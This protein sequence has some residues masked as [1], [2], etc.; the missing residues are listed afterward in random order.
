MAKY[1]YFP[2]WHQ[3]ASSCE[4]TINKDVW[5]SMSKR[6]QSLVEQA[7]SSCFI[8]GILNQD[9]HSG[10]AMRKNAEKYGVHNMIYPPEV[11]KAFQIT[12]LEIVAEKSATDPFFKKVWDDI[13]AFM[14]DYG[15]WEAHSYRAMPARKFK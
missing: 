14:K 4:L 8:K 15:I 2:G 12:W 10:P 11:L 1:N 13:S 7:A 3:P 6:Q 9:V 5:N